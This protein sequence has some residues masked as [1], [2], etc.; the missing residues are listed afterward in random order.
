[1]TDHQLDAIA[2]AFG[3]LLGLLRDADP[4]ENAELYARIGLRMTYRPGPETMI[5]EVATPAIGV[6]DG[7]PRP[8]VDPGY[9]P[10]F[11]HEVLIE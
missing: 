5:A 3:N 2:G 6:F 10:Q 11:T 7:G 9:A 1:M 4:R 8:D